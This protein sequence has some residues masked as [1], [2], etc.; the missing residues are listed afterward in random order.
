MIRRTAAVLTALLIAGCGAGSAVYDYGQV[1]EGAKG[2]TVKVE[3]G[4]GQRFS[5]EV[6]D[7]PSVGDSWELVELP[8]PKVASYISKEREAKS[9]QPG[10]SGAS[11]F[12]FNAKSPGTTTIK[13]F[14]CWRC[15]RDRVPVDEQS[16]QNSGEAVFQVT[17]E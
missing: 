14:D 8:D 4:K 3:I 15:P 16:K 2:R 1:T 17:V 13:L 10:A 5:L 11:R 7:N 12:V 6:D 9:D